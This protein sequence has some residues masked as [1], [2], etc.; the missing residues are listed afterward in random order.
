M[1]EEIHVFLTVAPGGGKFNFT[2][3]LL[4]PNVNITFVPIR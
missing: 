2:L 3:Q 1:E 4:Y